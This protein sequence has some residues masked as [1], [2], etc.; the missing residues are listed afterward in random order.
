MGNKETKKIIDL[1]R[2]LLDPYGYTVVLKP[3][4][5]TGEKWEPEN[6]EI[7]IDPETKEIISS[8]ELEKKIQDLKQQSVNLKKV[9]EGTKQTMIRF[10]NKQLPNEL[11]MD[12]YGGVDKKS[13]NQ[14]AIKINCNKLDYTT[15]LIV[16]LT[17]LKKI[18]I[19]QEMLEEIQQ[20]EG[21]RIT[22]LKVT[23]EVSGVVLQ[24]GIK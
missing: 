14:T 8:I 21:E 22:S 7:Y 5:E 19:K 15:K 24:I 20:Q 23:R 9:M 18:K 11:T 6:K 17:A 16:Y 12:L 4:P 13:I 10:M 2:T 1:Y 3:S